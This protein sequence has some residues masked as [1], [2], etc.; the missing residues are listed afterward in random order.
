MT[1]PYDRDCEHS[2][3]SGLDDAYDYEGR[4][5][6]TH[7]PDSSLSE[8]IA[9]GVRADATA[10]LPEYSL[11][12]LEDYLEPA[13]RE[14]FTRLVRDMYDFEPEGEEEALI[15]LVP[16]GEV[17]EDLT[18]SEAEVVTEDLRDQAIE[19]ASRDP[20]ERM[21]GLADWKQRLY[22]WHLEFA[23]LDQGKD[24]ELEDLD[25]FEAEPEEVT[26]TSSQE[27]ETEDTEALETDT[28][29]DQDTEQVEFEAEASEISESAD[30]GSGLTEETEFESGEDDIGSTEGPGSASDGSTEI[31]STTDVGERTLDLTEDEWEKVVDALGL[32]E[33]A[34]PEKVREELLEKLDLVRSLRA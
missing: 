12:D 32:D 17:P 30:S 23:L 19:H 28:T 10:A 2:I 25:T 13:Y 26:E 31:V 24:V 15:D 22:D 21:I 8:A 6:V 14:E 18:E 5:R 34:P 16:E 3:T 20:S 29:D 27:P 33:D 9:T 11:G 1:R 4:E 7:K